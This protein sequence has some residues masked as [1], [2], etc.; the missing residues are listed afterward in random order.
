MGRHLK[1]VAMLVDSTTQRAEVPEVAHSKPGPAYA[2][3]HTHDSWWLRVW[4][5]R[6][7][8]TTLESSVRGDLSGDVRREPFIPASA[9]TCVSA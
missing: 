3:G 9:V 2:Q 1:T 7:S 5:A 4:R 8:G 6:P